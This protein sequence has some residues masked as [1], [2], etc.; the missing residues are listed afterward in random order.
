MYLLKRKIKDLV[1]ISRF[2]ISYLELF[3]L[4]I[5]LRIMLATNFMINEILDS[6]LGAVCMPYP[7]SFYPLLLQ[8]L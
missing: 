3:Y 1:G 7:Q 6:L 2:L 4:Q 5:P 8:S